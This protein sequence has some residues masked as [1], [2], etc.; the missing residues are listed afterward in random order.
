MNRLFVFT[1]TILLLF[2]TG[3]AYAEEL[4]KVRLC[5]VVHSIFY[6]PQY[7]AF[8]L[9][10][11]ED[12]KLNVELSTAWGGDKAA[13]ALITN[14]CDIALIG[15]ETTIYIYK[16]GAENYLVNFAQLTNRA[17]SFLLA[18][19]PMP[20]FTW[21]DVRGK[22]IVGNRPGGAPQMVLEW[23]LKRHGIIPQK[24]V[25]II[26]NLDFTANAGA[27]SG[28]LGD[29]VQLFEPSASRLE[30]EKVGYV[31]ASLGASADPVPYTVYIARK[32]YIEENPEI[33]Q[34]F[35][36]AIYRAQKWVYSHSIDEIT[37]TIQSFF[38]DTDPELLYSVVKRYLEQDTWAHN[39]ILT[40]EVFDHW[41][42]IVIE[43]GVLDEKAPYEVLVNTIF[44]KKAVEMIQ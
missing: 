31:V 17:G 42:D 21:E 20:D 43:A 14:A 25:K 10:Y 27:F 24:D 23:V 7:I 11:F 44:A 19:K 1:L 26:T 8:N 22:V 12:E 37:N 28:G 40:K 29:F 3:A 5:E 9:G 33:I 34:K 36:N 39:P 30:S 18:R 13:T 41:Q 15:P 6:V 32:K 2:M 16:Q 4:I 38:P 35:T